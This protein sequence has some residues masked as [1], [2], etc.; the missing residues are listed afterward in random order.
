MRSRFSKIRNVLVIILALNWLVSALKIIYG[1]IS[2]SQA[3]SA[4]GF[5]SFADGASNIIGLVGI[6]I[7]S[8]PVD[9][10]HPYGHKKYETFT[11]LVI[12]LLL[13]IIA[14]HLIHDSI[15][16]FG[17][18]VMPQVTPISFIVMITTL[19]IN[20]IVVMFE[21]RKSRELKSD[22]LAADAQHTRSDILVSVS[23]I[24]TLLAIR[25][26][27]PMVD[28]IVTIAIALLIAYGA[29]MIIRESSAVLCD[30]Q[31]ILSDRIKDI[32]IGVKGVKDCHRIRTHGRFDDI[33]VD[34][35]VL[36]NPDMHVSKA[37]ELNDAIEKAVKK[38]VE[39]V[40]NI[41][42]HIEPYKSH[43]KNRI[44]CII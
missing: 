26:G 13:V 44:L 12:A 16:R 17:R 31:A 27:F 35:H 14:F 9:T 29:F 8:R 10:D 11:S 22:I 30:R 19:I 1:F 40:T 18:P 41:F 34:L 2:K 21:M 23:V 42:I 36:A 28:I 25:A 6:W 39:G 15:E 20:F 3:M 38:K 7:A 43:Q 37:H 32:V 4:D 24:A 5:H 33:H